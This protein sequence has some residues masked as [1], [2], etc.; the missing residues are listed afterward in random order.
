MILWRGG[1]SRNFKTVIPAHG[2]A[3][4]PYSDAVMF[5]FQDDFPRLKRG[6]TYAARVSR[7]DVAQMLE[8]FGPPDLT[9][10]RKQLGLEEEGR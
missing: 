3:R 8:L 10:V 4:H 6:H 1:R 7:N 9:E 5:Y 2:Y